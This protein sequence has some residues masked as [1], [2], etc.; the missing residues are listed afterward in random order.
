[1]LQEEPL[2]FHGMKSQ[3]QVSVVEQTLEESWGCIP[4]TF[5]R[6][7][8]G[9]AC[10]SGGAVGAAARALCCSYGLICLQARANFFIRFGTWLLM[11]N[12]A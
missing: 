1:M 11:W 6:L 9:S 8:L 2:V 5:P 3:E 10:R 12:K 7:G 4:T